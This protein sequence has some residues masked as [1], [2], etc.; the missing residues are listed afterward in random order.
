MTYNDYFCL[1]VYFGYPFSLFVI[2]MGKWHKFF[3]L[4]TI[5]NLAITELSIKDGVLRKFR[6]YKNI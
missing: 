1:H 5:L 4:W 3:A 2:V 6:P